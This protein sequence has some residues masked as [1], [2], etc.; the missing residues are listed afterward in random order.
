MIGT[1]LKNK[2][3]KIGDGKGGSGFKPVTS[4]YG[5]YKT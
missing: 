1:N 2:I 4:G 5:G 3:E